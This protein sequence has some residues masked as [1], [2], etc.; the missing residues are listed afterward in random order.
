MTGRLGL[1]EVTPEVSCGLYSARAVV[2]ERVP[3]AATVFREGHDAVNANVAWRAPDGTRMLYTPMTLGEPGLDR[4]HATI[5]PTS[6]GRWTFVVEAWSDPLATWWHAVE[7]KIEAGQGV[8]DLANDLESGARLLDRAARGVPR[9]RRAEVLAAASALRDPGRDL[10]HRVGPA[11]D[12][13]VRRL[14]RAYPVRDLVTRSRRHEIWVDRPRALYGAWYEIFPRSTGGRDE[15]GR[16]VH[17]TLATAVGE[18]PRIAAMGFDVVYLPPVHP[19]GRVNR[20]GKNNSL[21]AH[22]DDVGSPWA[23][24]AAE[25][26]HDA[27]HPD[28]GTIE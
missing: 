21:V 17:G 7:V 11:L 22:E 28:L 15:H 20:K 25:G 26:G 27:V 4:W 23:I 3:I 24:G 14:L 9:E 2:G 16:P 13:H 5:V 1:T 12:E 8:E 10:A 19:I 6:Q 18:L